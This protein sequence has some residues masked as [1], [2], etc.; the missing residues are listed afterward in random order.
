MGGG[1]LVG[2][3]VRLQALERGFVVTLSTSV[4]EL[5][6]RLAGDRKRPMLAGAERE[7]RVAELLEARAS[8]YAEAHAS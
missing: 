8:G 3:S 7:T 2:R 4:D 5:A 1:S 6:K